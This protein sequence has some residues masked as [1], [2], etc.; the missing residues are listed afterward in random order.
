MIVDPGKYSKG[1]NFLK[2]ADV[3]NKA[4]LIVDNA[5]EIT[6][7]RDG[8]SEQT[9][10]LRFRDV[11]QPFGLNMTNLRRMIELHGNDTKRWAGKAV[12][13]I[14]TMANNPK[15]NNKPVKTLR[16]Q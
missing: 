7:V 8:V 5:E 1:G 6:V 2:A 15:D 12:V 13:L 3:R 16:I 10:V 14:H 9:L 11:D 4:K